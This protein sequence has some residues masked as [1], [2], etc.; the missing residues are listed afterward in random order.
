VATGTI[1]G[2]ASKEQK[3][4]PPKTSSIDFDFETIVGAAIADLVVK[5][6]P[7]IRKSNWNGGSKR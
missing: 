1:A 2:K 6:R 4:P 3:A 7:R 5:K